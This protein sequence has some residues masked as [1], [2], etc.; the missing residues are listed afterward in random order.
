MRA[1][2]FNIAQG[3]AISG[4]G[5]LSGLGGGNRT[6]TLA[7]ID[8]EGSILASGGNLLL[9][10]A[11]TGTG[12]L[13]IDTNSTMTLQA[14]VGS[15]QAL[16]F[17]QNATAVLNDARAFAGTITG[18]GARRRAGSRQHAGDQR[19]SGPTAS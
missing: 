6:V 11:V 8:N 3:G 16:A 1:S 2:A 9:Y 14:A 12:T 18:F 5:T 4:A 15:G 10:G 17:G 19:A 13:L 7:S